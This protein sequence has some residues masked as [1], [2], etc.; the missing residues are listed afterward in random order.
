[1]IGRSNRPSLSRK[2]LDLVVAL[3]LVLSVQWTLPMTAHAATPTVSPTLDTFGFPDWYQDTTGTRLEPCLDAND[4]FCVVLP[5]PGVFDPAFPMTMP[6]NFPDEFFYS[7]VDSDRVDTPGCDGTRPGRATLRVALEGA[8]VNGVPAVGEQ[9]VF[10]RVRVRVTSGLCPNTTYTF[11]HPYGTMS[12]TTNELGGTRVNEG[13]QDIGCLPIAPATCDFALAANSPVAKSFLRSTD[14][15][16]PAGYLGDAVTLSTITGATY[17]PGSGLANYFSISDAGGEILRTD[18]F[19][20]MGKIAGPLLPAPASLDFGGQDVDLGQAPAKTVTLTNVGVDP[21]TVSAIAASPAGR[22]VVTGTTCFGVTLARDASCTVSV[23]F[24]PALV[25]ELVGTLSIAHDGIRMPLV[26]PLA[27]TGINP[28]QEAVIT[29]NPLQLNFGNVRIRTQTVAQRIRVTNTG[30]APLQFTSISL[31]DVLAGDPGDKDQFVITSNACAGATVQPTKKCDISISARPVSSGLVQAALHLV[32]NSNPGHV[33]IPLSVVGTGGIAAVSPVID[34]ATGF[35]TWY[36]DEN[37]LRL[38]ECIDPA[39]PNCIVLADAT[40]DPALPLQGRPDFANFPGEF[41]YTVTD[42]DVLTTPGCGSVL[43]GRA[44]IRAA[45]EAAFLNGAPIDAEQMTFGRVRIVVRGGLCPNTNYTFTHPYGTTVLRTDASGGIKP[46]AG[47]VDI[48]CVPVAPAVCDFADA[49][50]SP[51]FASFLQWDPAVAP[52]APAGYIGDAVTLHRITGSPFNTNLF[53]ID[54]PVTAGGANVTVAQ[55]NL[56]TVMGKLDGPL[57]ANPSSVAFPPQTVGVTTQT[58]LV[59]LTN[60]GIGSLTVNSLVVGGADP[61]DFTLDTGCAA[62]VLAPSTSC[63]FSVTFAPTAVGFRNAFITVEHTGRN[64]GF[65]ITIDGIGK[66][67]AGPAISVNPSSL[68]FTDLHVGQVSQSMA[69]TVSNLGGLEPLEVATPVIDN[70]LDFQLTNLCPVAPDTVPIDGSCIIKVRFTPTASGHRSGT[71][72]IPSNVV[73]AVTTVTVGGHGFGGAPAASSSIRAFDGFPDWYQDDNG[74]RVQPCLDPADPN[75]IV[76]A[77]TGFDPGLPLAFPANYPG[78]FFYQIADSD[79]IVTPGCGGT[80]AGTAT[81]RAAL[82]GSFANGAPAAGEQIT[83]AR[84]RIVVTRGLCANQQYTFTTPYGPVSFLTNSVGGIPANAG[85]VDIGCAPVQPA[86]CDFAE[87][88]AGPVASAGFLRWDPAFAPAP[89]PGYLGDAVTLHR[90]VGSRH[91]PAGETEPAN[92][93]AIDGTNLRTDLFSVSGHLA[94]PIIDAPASLD[95]ANVDVGSVSADQTV[96]LT[97]V[98]NLAVT[99]LTPSITGADASQ[100]AVSGG[101]CTGAT[102][103]LD[104]SCTVTIRFAP[105]TVG[106][107]SAQLV[108]THSGLNS[109]ADVPLFGQAIDV[110]RP[111][112]GLDPTSLTFGSQDVGTVSA[113]QN[114]VVTNTGT[115]DLIVTSATLAGANPGDFQL[116]NGCTLTVAPG[117]TCTLQVRFAPTASGSRTARVQLVDNAPSSPQLVNLSGTGVAASLSLSPTSLSFTNIGVGGSSTKSVNITN[118][119]TSNLVI[120]SLTITGSTTF[121]IANHNCGAP[122]APGKN[123]TVNVRFAPNVARSTFT[124]T[125]NVSSNATGAPHT[126]PLS[127]TSK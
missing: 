64:T 95:F 80:T 127:G 87:A 108:V 68:T 7:V 39:D 88:L 124:G 38:G 104:Q 81:L 35:P 76:L 96:T 86:T 91:V 56:F 73:G 43:P 26:V 41:F 105:T 84:I 107:K 47:T 11:T 103:S 40:F 58:Q 69:I 61:G 125:L 16:T 75:C 3:A 100:F 115:A 99:G 62:A 4:P 89:P 121:T 14:P 21:L 18:Q 19:T 77:D 46:A 23:A 102:L 27:G 1:M 94:G 97:N 92:Y 48:G 119:G 10:G 42:S 54:G 25:G 112:V 55:T 45:V 117:G 78:E 36:Q 51:I 114:V 29:A 120:S 22:F 67:A 34:G 12:V 106:G 31:I 101:T 44:F 74:V 32:A 110:P 79:A 71:I 30:S 111:A 82:E 118:T 59:T 63:T 60:D 65:K 98:S 70:G 50:Q 123:C 20:V 90:I 116:T 2:S 8:F 53:R 9:M 72:T 33:D 57:V 15:A 28:G 37:G 66:A 24:D 113:A 93:F 17:D 122:V 6:D 5:N 49:L 52:A 85:T 13:T 83:F 109:P 126:V